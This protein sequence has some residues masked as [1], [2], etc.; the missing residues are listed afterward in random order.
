MS[1]LAQTRYFRICIITAAVTAFLLMSFSL[2]TQ[3]WSATTPIQRHPD[4]IVSDATAST[5][6]ASP[7]PTPSLQ[8]PDKTFTRTVVIAKLEEED[9]SWI[10]TLVQTDPCLSSAVYT[11]DNPNATLTVPQNKGHEVMVYLTYIIDHYASLSDVTL[12]MHAHQFTW[13]N[14]DF[15]NSDSALQVR[16]LRSEYVLRNGYVNLRCHLGPGCPDHI[17]P[18]VAG[19]DLLN[20]PEAAVFGNS[21]QELFPGV[22]VPSVLSQPCCGQFAVSAE[23]IRTVALERYVRYRE[24]LLATP[25]EDKLSGRVWEYLWQWLFTGREEYCPDEQVCYCEGYGVCFGEG[26]YEEYFRLRDESRESE[27]RVEELNQS[28]A[29]VEEDIRSLKDHIDEL[30]EKMSAIKSKAVS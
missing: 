18:T 28:E 25:L 1:V 8:L 9:A 20:I 12:F 10:D 16:R 5:A 4:N 27:R 15:L 2:S 26:E 29:F 22:P 30:H 21:W 14:N 19:D 17:H 3:R 13:H 7:W 23:R 6:S 11:V 24:W